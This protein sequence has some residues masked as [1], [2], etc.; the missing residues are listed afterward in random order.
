LP[1]RPYQRFLPILSAVAAVLF[2]T[3]AAEGQQQYSN[4]Q[5]LSLN[6]TGG[7]VLDANFF[8]SGTKVGRIVNVVAIEFLNLT[9]GQR[10]R[11]VLWPR[12]GNHVHLGTVASA[13]L[14]ADGRRIVTGSY[15]GT[16]RVWSVHTGELLAELNAVEKKS[17]PWGVIEVAGSADGERVVVGFGDGEVWLWRPHTGD[18]VVKLLGHSGR[19]TSLSISAD[20]MRV[21][22][23]SADGTARVWR[24]ET[25]KLL[26]TLKLPVRPEFEGTSLGA[27]TSVAFDHDGMR[28][29]TGSGDGK[30]RLWYAYTGSLIGERVVHENTS[31]DSV[32]FSPDGRLGLAESRLGPAELWHLDTGEPAEILEELRHRLVTVAFS[33]DGERMLVGD[34]NGSVFIVE[35]GNVASRQAVGTTAGRVLHARFIGRE[36]RAA[37]VSFVPAVEFV[38]IGSG[39]R[40]HVFLWKEPGQDPDLAAATH[41]HISTD[42]TFVVTRH[43]DGIARVWRT[44]TGEQIAELKGHTDELTTVAISPDGR[45]IATGSFD[46]TARLWRPETGELVAELTGHE[47]AVSSVAFSPDG[48]YVVTGSLDRTARVWRA[49]SGALV[50]ELRTGPALRTGLDTVIVLNR[51][52]QSSSARASTERRIGGGA[53]DVRFSARRRPT[54]NTPSAI[55]KSSTGSFALGPAGRRVTTWVTNGELRIWDLD[56]CSETACPD[57]AAMVL[58]T[59]TVRV[60]AFSPDGRYLLTGGHEETP[61]LWSTSNGLLLTQFVGHRGAIGS[62]S[63]DASGRRVL[64]T[65]ADGTVR[66]WEFSPG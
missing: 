28:V 19:I 41:W 46:D 23:G 5:L 47:L 17:R 58:M 24:T 26:S 42:G 14:S 18:P 4:R 40:K 21:V 20:G 38:D 34:R 10:T 55:L 43:W 1:S 53:H 6:G 35:P 51:H 48:K 30:A 9:T 7:R 27:V 36:D 65:G 56:R 64:T 25:G 3:T 39:A 22:T 31:L 63:F 8:A 60:Q 66:L 12:G 62:A 57:D 15:D 11:R 2:V 16:A 59:G 54:S 61:K 37:W 13:Q 49:P 52:L 45:L 33:G 29:L 44:D 32:A 50:G